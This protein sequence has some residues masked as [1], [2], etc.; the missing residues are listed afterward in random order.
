VPISSN[1]DQKAAVSPVGPSFPPPPPQ[2]DQSTHPHDQ[3]HAT[4]ADA[5]G[6][7]HMQYEHHILLSERLVGE[8][9]LRL[10]SPNPLLSRASELAWKTVS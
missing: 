4:F 10:R 5:P 7:Q 2:S 1:E 9:H 3:G 6:N 8:F